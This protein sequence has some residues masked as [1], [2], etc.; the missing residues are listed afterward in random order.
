MDH[1]AVGYRQLP[2]R[3]NSIDLA[4]EFPVDPDGP[5]RDWVIRQVVDREVLITRRIQSDGLDLVGCLFGSG[6]FGRRGKCNYSRGSASAS[7]TCCDAQPPK[8]IVAANPIA[9]ERPE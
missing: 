7:A 9:A 2:L 1:V 3:R 4:N 8:M 5:R 6:V